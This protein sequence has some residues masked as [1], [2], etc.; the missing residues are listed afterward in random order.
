VA[1][2]QGKVAF[3]TGGLRGIGLAIVERFVAEGARTVVADITPADDSEALGLIERLGAHARYVQLDVAD[4]SAWAGAAK[5]LGQRE[6]RLDIL[7][8]NAGVDCTGAVETLEFKAWRRVMSINLDGVFLGTRALT[9]LLAESGRTTPAGSSIVNVSSILGLTGFAEA[10]GYSASKGGVR[11]FSKSI[12][13]EF[14]QKR[15]P[16]RV[17]SLHPAFVLTPLLYQGMQRWVDQGLAGSAQELI[18]N[19]AQQTPIGRVAEPRE[20]AAAALFLASD[21]ASYVTGAELAVDGGW[22]AH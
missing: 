1:R 18:D 7:V 22:T 8:N 10:S 19:L 21:D 6:S 16:I 14:A 15:M 17:N 4:E 5:A 11:L 13:I 12:A 9:P 20:I 2:L 3:V